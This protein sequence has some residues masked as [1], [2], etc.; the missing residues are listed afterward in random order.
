FS[1][2]LW[3]HLYIMSNFELDVD[4][5]FERPE[6]DALNKKPEKLDYPSRNFRYKHYGRAIELLI[7]KAITLENPQE[8]QAMTE[9][10]ANLMKR[11]YLMWNRDSVNDQVI[12]DHLYELTDGQLQLRP[13]FTLTST[14]DILSKNNST[15]QG[16]KKKRPQNNKKKK[17][18]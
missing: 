18:Y 6:P 4:S 12:L 15:N 8:K 14:S 13:E 2:K 10:V 17:K 16:K 5:P 3:D 11:S 9:A 1:H 7:K